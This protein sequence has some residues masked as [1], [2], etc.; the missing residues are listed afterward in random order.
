MQLKRRMSRGPGWRLRSTG[1]PGTTRGDPPVSVSVSGT[2]S[3]VSLSLQSSPRGGGGAESRL[4]VS[5]IGTIISDVKNPQV[6]AQ[7]QSSK[8]YV[9]QTAPPVVNVLL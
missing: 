4:R 5:I 9:V 7:T 2:R 3:D 6:T 8:E 1:R